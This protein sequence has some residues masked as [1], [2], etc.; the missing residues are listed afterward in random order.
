MESAPD[1]SQETL[2]ETD[3][4]ARFNNIFFWH[5]P[6]DPDKPSL[7]YVAGFSVQISRH[8]PPPAF[9]TVEEL[10]ELGLHERPRLSQK[11]LEKVAHS[12]AVVTNPPEAGISLPSLQAETAQLV[13]TSPIATGSAR[14]PQIVACRVTPQEGDSFTAVAKI[15]DPFCY[16]FEG[17]GSSPRDT[18]YEADEHYMVETWAY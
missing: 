10:E 13:I 7:P 15:Y 18:I 14:G 9:P 4:S 8:A 16:D 3:K 11:Y 5:A 1:T 2:P 17:L 12:E 6:K